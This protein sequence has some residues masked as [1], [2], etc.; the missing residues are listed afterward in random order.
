MCW[1][2][3]FYHVIDLM[4]NVHCP[5]YYIYFVFN[6]F[7]FCVNFPIFFF[8]I[9]LLLKSIFFCI[10]KFFKHDWRNRIHV[11][12]YLKSFFC[13]LGWNLRVS[14]FFKLHYTFLGEKK[15][16]C[17]YP[18]VNSCLQMNYFSIEKFGCIVVKYTSLW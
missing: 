8:R 7:A 6:C 4:I 2:L 5:V 10:F 3:L 14:L 11:H 18:T 15:F 12:V 17:N 16:S 13:T 9:L 1:F